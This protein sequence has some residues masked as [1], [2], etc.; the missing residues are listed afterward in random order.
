VGVLLLVRHGQ[1]SYGADNYD[2][3]SE[4]GRRQA[5]L[6][7]RR[8]ASQPVARVVS[9]SMQRQRDTAELLGLTDDVRVDERLDEYDHVSLLE[10]FAAGGHSL[11]GHPQDVLDSALAWWAADGPPGDGSHESHEGFV[12]RVTA[13]LAEL[14]AEPGLTVAAT[15]GGVISV[16][17]AGWLR[18]PEG[19][20]PLLGR[21]IVNASVTKV[22]TGRTGTWLL[23]LN[24]HAHFEDDRALITYR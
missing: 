15:S 6:L 20:W 13:A 14:A 19:S 11:E 5:Q 4:L 16:A 2:E 7:G 1:A 23:T 22:V 8:L 10:S 18:M 3:L 12:A 24:D 17:A 9:G 21:V